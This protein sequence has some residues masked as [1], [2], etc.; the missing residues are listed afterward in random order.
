MTNIVWT[1]HSGCFGN[2]AHLCSRDQFLGIVAG[3]DAGYVAPEEFEI[4]LA[5]GLTRNE[6]CQQALLRQFIQRGLH[7][8]SLVVDDVAAAGAKRI[9]L[10]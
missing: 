8:P 7:F 3:G 10:R 2:S 1:R 9:S 6:G 5:G 4:V